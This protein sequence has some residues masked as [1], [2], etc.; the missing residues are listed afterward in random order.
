MRSVTTIE[1][2]YLMQCTHEASKT[3]HVACKKEYQRNQI[4]DRDEKTVTT[5]RNSHRERGGK[6]HRCRQSRFN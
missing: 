2:N 1:E 5:G 6:Q 3:H 4:T